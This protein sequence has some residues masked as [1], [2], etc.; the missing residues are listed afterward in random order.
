M[1]TS[2]EL[3]AALSRRFLLTEGPAYSPARSPAVPAV[4]VL[5]A[6]ATIPATSGILQPASTCT[7]LEPH[8]QPCAVLHQEQMGWQQQWQQQQQRTK[9]QT[10]S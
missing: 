8:H 5:P 9:K 2:P 6:V 1:L 4:S 3:Q 10:L 7:R